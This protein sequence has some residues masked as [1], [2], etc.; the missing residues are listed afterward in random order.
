MQL[1]RPITNC[2]GTVELG[3]DGLELSAAKFYPRALLPNELADIYAGGAP[4]SEIATSAVLR[5][6][7]EDPFA[8]LKHAAAASQDGTAEA[9]DAENARTAASLLIS[10]RALAEGD[11]AREAS[12]Y[13]ADDSPPAPLA[14]APEMATLLPPREQARWLAQ[15]GPANLSTA[16]AETWRNETA[17]R[18][19][20]YWAMW[21]GSLYVENY[22]QVG[23]GGER[24]NEGGVGDG[25]EGRRRRRVRVDG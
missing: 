23:G 8:Q 21:D 20:T 25:G 18:I 24:G 2:I 4:L 13:T 7:D 3:A 16:L 19:G 15:G 14:L 9:L 10:K 5:V 11:D 1:P 22:G 12:L 6:N 17:R